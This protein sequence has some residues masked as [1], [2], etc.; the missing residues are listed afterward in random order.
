M[1]QQWLRPLLAARKKFVLACPPPN[2]E[3]HPIRQLLKKLVPDIES[4]A[5]DLDTALGSTLLGTTAEVIPPQPLPAPP[6]Q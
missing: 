5:L 4:G 6:R 1:A 2:A 3:V